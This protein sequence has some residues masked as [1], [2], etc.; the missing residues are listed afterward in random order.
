LPL[1]KA[2]VIYDPIE[3]PEVKERNRHKWDSLVFITIWRLTA[4]KNIPSVI[5][6]L[7]VIIR[8]TDFRPHLVVV[9][10]GE[11]RGALE[12]LAKELQVDAYVTFKGYQAHVYGVLAEGDLFV[13]P[14]YLEGSSLALAEAMHA[15]LPSIVINIGG[16]SEIL[17]DSGSGMLIDPHRLEDL[18]QAM[19]SFLTLN[20]SVRREMGKSVKRQAERFSVDHHCH[21]LLKLYAAGLSLENKS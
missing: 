21:E 8:E 1:S 20:P 13:L 15:G 10:V 6:A 12:Q 2:Q 16:A 3:L 19:L 5:R 17:G 7:A 14:S 18:K 9:G 11:E 4:I